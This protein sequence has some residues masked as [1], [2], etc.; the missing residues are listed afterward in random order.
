[1]EGMLRLIEERIVRFE[2]K[3]DRAAL[4]ERFSER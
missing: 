3:Q 2:W 1:M 4:R